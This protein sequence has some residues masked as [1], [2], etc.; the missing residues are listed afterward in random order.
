MNGCLVR[1]ICVNVRV[2]F[3]VAETCAVR[4]RMFS[5]LLFLVWRFVATIRTDFCSASVTS[6]LMSFLKIFE[7]FPLV[8]YVRVTVELRYVGHYCQFRF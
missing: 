4:I 2:F 5:I 6:D 1:V 7:N 8:S 3:S